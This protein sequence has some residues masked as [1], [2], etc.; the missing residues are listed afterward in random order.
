MP[1]K[2]SKAI[3]EDNDPV[4]QQEEFG[5]DQPTMADVYRMIEE[6]FDKLDR[7]L[8]ELTENL[9]ATDQ[10]VASLEQDARQPRLAMEADLPADTKTRERTEGAA[11]AVQAMH[12]DSFSANLVD[13][14]P[15]SS[16]SFGDDS[17]GR[18]A[19]HCS[20]DDALVDSGAVAPKSYL[21]PL[22]MGSPTAASGLVPAGKAST[23]TRITFYQPRLRFCPTE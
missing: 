8:Y 18:R 4:S 16:T 20:T 3:P 7:K 1:R 5:S 23:T 2:E 11:I 17:A 22:E 13:P 6:L 9:R 21:S 10:R 15:K 19:L 12:G 14:N